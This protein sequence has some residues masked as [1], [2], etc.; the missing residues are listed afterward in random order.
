M[1]VVFVY[2]EVYDVARFGKTRKEFPPFG[3]LYL[4]TIVS[5]QNGMEVEILSVDSDEEKLDLTRF[6]VVAFSIPSSMTYSIIKRVRFGSVYKMDALII[7]GGVHANIFPEQVLLDLKVHAVGVGQGDESILELLHEKDTK[8][9]IRIK[10]VCFVANGKAVFTDQRMLKRN[11]DH[12]PVIPARHLLP[13]SDFVMTDRLSNT[14]LRMT[15]VMLSLGCPFSC[16][17]CASQQRRMQY[18]SGYYVRQELK[19]LKDVHEIEGFAVVGD[20]FLVNKR[21]VRDISESISDLGLKWSTLSRV[22]MVEHDILES[23]YDAGCIEVKFG[24]ESGSDKI[25]KAMGKRVSVDQIYNAIK[26]THSVGIKVKVFIIHGYPSENMETTQET[27]TMLE[28]LSALIERVSLF[29]FVPLP[30]SYV[31]G[32]VGVGKPFIKENSWSKCHVHYNP[33]HWWGND[34]DF[35]IVEESYVNLDKFVLEKWG[36]SFKAV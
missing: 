27:I 5:A 13:D 36:Q 2:P 33:Y 29:R 14:S 3:V 12:L 34:N 32:E 28:K 21:R 23:M 7:A 22:D 31:Y 8:Q 18:R 10:G 16:N 15:H 11:L 25:L 19:H 35:A 4:A 20:N 30:G 9:F 26:L 6:D 24:I 1:K 17:F